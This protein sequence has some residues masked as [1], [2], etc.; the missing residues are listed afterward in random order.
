MDNVQRL[1]NIIH[2]K[3][4][5]ILAQ[6]GS[7]ISLLLVS[8]S[9]VIIMNQKLFDSNLVTN[10]IKMFYQIDQLTIKRNIV[11]KIVEVHIN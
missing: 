2:P 5:E 9:V 4:G 10:F 1:E 11:R 7:I 8:R 6:I 3:L